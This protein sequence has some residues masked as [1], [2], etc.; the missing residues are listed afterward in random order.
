MKNWKNWIRDIA[1][2]FIKVVLGMLISIT[3]ITLIFIMPVWISRLVFWTINNQTSATSTYAEAWCIGFLSI[4]I[5]LVLTFIFAGLGHC[6]YN[7]IVKFLR[8]KGLLNQ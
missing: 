8:K 2:F 6:A 5:A 1:I 7:D 3:F 4:L